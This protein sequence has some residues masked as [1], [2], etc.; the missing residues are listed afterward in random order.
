MAEGPSK[1]PS[2]AWRELVSQWEKS[3]NAL[4]NQNMASDE[5]SSGTNQAMN[6]ALKMQQGMASGMATYLA[7]LNLPS[8]A[9]ITALGERLQAMEAY[10]SRIA[11]ALE[12][13]GP[14]KSRGAPKRSRP[15]RTKQPPTP[16]A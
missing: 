8:R 12:A 16:P 6:L 5:F 13:P 11:L 10:L 9:D 3:I 14:G 4:A 2:A 7:T 1:D 15:P